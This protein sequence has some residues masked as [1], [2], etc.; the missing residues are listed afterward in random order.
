M[1]TRCAIGMKRENGEVAAIYCHNDGYPEGVGAILGR[2][3]R[4]AE[5]VEALLK[6]GSISSLG[7]KL[8]P[9]AGAEHTFFNRQQ[10]VTYAY[11]RDRK[12]PETSATVYPSVKSYSENARKDFWADFL[13]LFDNGKWLVFGSNGD[14]VEIKTEK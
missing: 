13:Y 10:D 7:A 14:W 9:E 11:H 2:W 1:S 4:N 12:E 3:Y 6:L 5:K 8:E